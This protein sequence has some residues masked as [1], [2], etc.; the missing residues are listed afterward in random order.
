MAPS[1]EAQVKQTRRDLVAC[2]V[3]PYELVAQLLVRNEELHEQV[4]L[5]QRIVNRR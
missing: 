1:I 4:Q 5:L 3:D 2:G